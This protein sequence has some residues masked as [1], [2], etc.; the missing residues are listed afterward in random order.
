MSGEYTNSLSTE[1]ITGN[2]TIKFYVISAGNETAQVVEIHHQEMQGPD[3]LYGQWYVC[4]RP[5]D[6]GIQGTSR[7]NTCN[8]DMVSI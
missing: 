1:F 4:W 8:M 2:M 6:A 7:P 5:G 3:F